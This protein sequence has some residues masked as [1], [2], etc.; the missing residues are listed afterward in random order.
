MIP[1]QLLVLI[2]FI[3]AKSSCQELQ[4][5]IS[6]KKTRNRIVLYA[7]N[8]TE[9]TLNV[10][11]MVNAEGY[12]KSASKPVIKNIAP[13]DKV[14]MATLIELK[15]QPSRYTYDLIIDK[16]ENN[17]HFTYE[18]QAKDIRKLIEG[19]LV[20]FSMDNCAKCLSL[21]NYLTEQRIAHRIFDITDDA[22]LYNQFMQLIERDL[23][24][25]TRIRF[26]VIWNKNTVIFGYDT[27]EDIKSQLSI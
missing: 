10:F 22:I 25:E 13:G 3:A 16:S 6:E 1:K 18:K 9:D 15:D 27:L 2:V 19:K 7:E 12:R 14:P 11:F 26:P 8:K 20:I 24:N 4:V 5:L 21:S 17:L 23:T